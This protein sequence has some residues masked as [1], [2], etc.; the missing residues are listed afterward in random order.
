MA[1]TFDFGATGLSRFDNLTVWSNWQIYFW[2]DTLVMPHL[3]ADRWIPST[4]TPAPT[5]SGSA[6]Y[7]V[8]EHNGLRYLMYPIVDCL[9]LPVVKRWYSTSAFN[10]LNHTAG[11][12]LKE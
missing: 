2:L 1:L 5:C 10:A 9:V 6:L 8:Y 11:N 4:T 12:T 3:S 7:R